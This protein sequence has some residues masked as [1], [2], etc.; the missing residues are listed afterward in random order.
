MILVSEPISDVALRRL[1]AVRPVHYD[2]NLVDDPGRLLRLLPEA[3]AWLV[4]NRSPVLGRFLEAARCL[5]VVGRL[6]SGVDNI[7]VAELSKRG[8]ALVTARGANAVSVA[9]WVLAYILSRLK[10]LSDLDRSVRQGLWP[11][12]QAGFELSGR[13]LGILGFGATGRAL[14]ERAHALGMRVLAY[15]PHLRRGARAFAAHGA[16]Q[17]SFWEV[18]RQ[19]DFLSLHVPLN[20]STVHLIGRPVLAAM[21]PHA[22]LIQTARG[23]VV[24][25]EALYEALASGRLS[26]ALIDVRSVEP[27]RPDDP[28]ARLPNVVLT[29][30]V[31]GLAAEARLRVDTWVAEEVARRLAEDAHTRA[32]G[33]GR[34]PSAP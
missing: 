4:R 24:D 31:A 2:P 19:S 21:K 13:S 27:P 5:L 34:C 14:A 15:D 16:R 6:G 3:E 28:F 18:V 30:H 10:P 23:D 20:P 25:E 1:E 33:I 29:P 32:G 8:V 22:H 11:R 9:E 17:A 12:D 7:D 26:G